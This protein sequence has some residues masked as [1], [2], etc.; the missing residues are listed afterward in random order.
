MLKVIIGISAVVLISLK[1]L[2]KSKSRVKV[3]LIYFSI[4]VMV[5]IVCILIR[6]KIFPSIILLDKLKELG[7]GDD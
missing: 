2:I 6:L 4:I 3:M 7:I 1:E 5:I